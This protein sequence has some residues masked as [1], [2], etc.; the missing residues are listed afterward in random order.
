MFPQDQVDATK[1]KLSSLAA[2]QN[3]LS[4]NL[5]TKDRTSFII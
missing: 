1:A 2:F 3:S 4:F 5:G